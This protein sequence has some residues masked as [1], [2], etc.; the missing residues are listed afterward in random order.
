MAGHSVLKEL[1][2]YDT[3]P[4]LR[5]LI[6][7]VKDTKVRDRTQF[8]LSPDGSQVAVLN[9]GVIQVFTLPPMD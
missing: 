1:L 4:Q 6:F 3:T 9:D 5:G 7:D 2:V 8:A